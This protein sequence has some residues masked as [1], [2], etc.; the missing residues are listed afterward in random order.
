MDER[1]ST[2]PSIM[3]VAE[4][5]V[6]EPLVVPAADVAAQAGAVAELPALEPPVLE[7]LRFPVADN[8]A[9]R[10]SLLPVLKVP[11]ARVV[12]EARLPA[13]Q[14]APEVRLRVD[15]VVRLRRVVAEVAAV[16]KPVAAAVKPVAA[17][18]RL[19]AV[20]AA[21][22]V[23]Q[24]RV[25]RSSTCCW[26][27][28]WM[29][30]RNSTCA[31]P[32]TR[33]DASAIRCSARERRRYC[34][35]WSAAIWK[36]LDSWSKRVQVR[37]SMAWDSRRSSMSPALRVRRIGKHPAAVAVAAALPSIWSFSIS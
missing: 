15:P 20:R 11:V 6:P 5:A 23:L 31:V 37:T 9:R 2:S 35:P 8:P 36:S 7:F 18:V 26:R 25:R 3:Q 12:P 10:L 22:A 21:A 33:A 34:E 4:L 30:I 19:P 24:F 27:P 13:V 1:H 28:V 29:S 14:V 17:V 16:L 32:A